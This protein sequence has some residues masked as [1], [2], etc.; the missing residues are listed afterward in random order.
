MNEES[1]KVGYVAIIGKPNVGKSSLINKLIGESIAITTP[2]PQT[3]RFNIKGI[4]TTKTSQLIFVDT[5]GIHLGQNKLTKYMMSGVENISKEADLVLFLID[6]TK[7]RLDDINKKML[8]ELVNL[9]K[10]IIL[11]INKIDKIK[12]ENLLN[13]IT[14][15]NNYILEKNYNYLEIIPIS[16]YKLDGIELL[17]SKIEENIP[18]GEKLFSE[19][20]FTDMTERE[21]VE[22][23]IREKLLNNLEEEVP[24]G[25]FVQVNEFKTKLNKNLEEVYNIEVDIICEK[26]SHKGIVIGKEGKMINLIKKISKE[27]IERVLQTKINLKFWVKV[28]QDWQKQENYLQNIKQ[29]ANYK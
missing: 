10:K 25:I 1:Y 8:E 13:I 18:V 17:V 2:K 24:H 20:E 26:M 11:V 3:T 14:E 23:I 15:Y 22:E 29:R 19:D 7:P 6:A 16:T 4:R 9:K 28:R 27:S 5:P 12:K 21:I